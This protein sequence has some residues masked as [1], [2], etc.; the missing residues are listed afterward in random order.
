MSELILYQSPDG[1]TKVH[2]RAENGNVWLAQSKIAELFSNTK[3]N[4]SLHINNILAEGEFL[5][6]SVVKEDLTTATDGKRH[7]TKLYRLDM[8]LAVGFRVKGSRSTQIRQFWHYLAEGGIVCNQIKPLE[9]LALRL[10][11][12]G[13]APTRQHVA[14]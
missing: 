13:P 4:I 11:P 12:Q 2:L 14:L 7:R 8:I 6:Q 5:E 3:Q 9:K 10:V 1:K